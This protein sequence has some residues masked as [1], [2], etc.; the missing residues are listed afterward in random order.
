MQALYLA[1]ASRARFEQAQRRR[2]G[3]R[4]RW[5]ARAASSACRGRCP[6][7]AHARPARSRRTRPSASGGC[8][9]AATSRRGRCRLTYDPRAAV[10]PEQRSPEQA[11]DA[12]AA[13]LGAHRGRARRRA[14][15]VE[16][17]REYRRRSERRP[18]RRPWTSSPSAPAST[19]RACTVRAP[20]RWGRRGGLC[21]EREA[22]GSPRPATSPPSGVRQALSSSR[23][24]AWPPRPRRPGRRAH[25]LCARHRRDRRDRP[26]RRAGPGPP[27]AHAR[28]RLPPVRGDRRTRWWTSCPRPSSA[29]SP[30]C[31]QGRPLTFVAGPS[32]TSDIELNRVEGVHGP[33]T[34][35]VVVLASDHG[36]VGHTE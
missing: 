20:A 3:P 1:F 15:P 30:R 24:T 29:S 7:G 2:G 10:G 11:G 5:P 17:P 32:A 8:A 27:R 34:L 25:G 12:R 16:I 28:A 14:A 9:S 6:A 18:R 33:R 19:A 23:M 31:E 36:V 22:A 35:H 21:R 26:R 4:G 13:I